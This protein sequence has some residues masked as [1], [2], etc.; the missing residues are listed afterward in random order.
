MPGVIASILIIGV[1]AL[2][3]FLI[4]RRMFIKKNGIEADA[5]IS[6]IKETPGESDDDG[7]RTI[8]LIY[9]VKYRTQDGTEVEARLEDEP[10][11]LKVGDPVKIKYLP[12]KPK[13]VILSK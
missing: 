8:H 2:F 13:Y 7:N 11:G 1:I 4:G 5:V 3:V 10:E 6:D 9:H 12:N